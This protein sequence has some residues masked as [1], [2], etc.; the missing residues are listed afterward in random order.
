MPVSKGQQTKGQQATYLEKA[1][2]IA[3]AAAGSGAQGCVDPG[4]LADIIKAT[5]DQMVAIAESFNP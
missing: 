4:L 2:E 1:A 5:Y 3:K